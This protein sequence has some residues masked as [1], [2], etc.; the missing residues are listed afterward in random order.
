MKEVKE[1]EALAALQL[2]QVKAKAA[3]KKKEAEELAK[4][5]IKRLEAQQK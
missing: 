5:E 4:L 2:E 3:L 1:A